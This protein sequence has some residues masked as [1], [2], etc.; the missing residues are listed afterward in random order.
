MRAARGAA[1]LA[2][3]VATGLVLSACTPAEPEESS[4]V[5]RIATVDNG[6]MKRMQELADEFNASNRPMEIVFET[7]REGELRQQVTTDINTGGGR[8]D[9]VTLGT[10]E[11]PIWAERG[12]L[13]P[14]DAMPAAYQ[15][16]DIL[17]TIRES[18]SY[19]GSLYA[20]PFYGESSFT[21][22]R[23]D[24]FEEAGIEMPEEP[25]WDFIVDAATRLNDP[26][27]GVN[28]ACLRGA[29]G[30]GENMALLTSMANSYGGRWFDDN[31][32]PQLETQPWVDALT[33][34]TELGANADP[35][36]STMG[37]NANLD[38]FREGKCAIWIDATAAGSF[39]VDPEGSEVADSVGFAKAPGTGLEKNSNWLWAW[40]LAVTKSAKNKDVATEFVT[41]ATS[42][43]YTELVAEEYGWGNVPP[44]ARLS[45]Y[46]NEDYLKAAPYADLA[47]AAIQNSDPADPTV[48]PV[49]YTGVQYVSVPEFQGIGTAVGNRVAL[50]L[51]GQLSVAQALEDSQWVTTEVS[52]R[53]RLIEEAN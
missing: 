6:D 49:P 38:L 42:K 20:L 26:E 39:I 50:A 46:E 24:L 40:S 52:D 5:L 34:Y 25:D 37:Y 7:M 30:W 9:I 29:P 36:S 19:D 18:L 43:E 15:V 21:M 53:I 2:V 44:G 14:M 35:E 10:Y 45:L 3:A 51:Q 33:T 31:W 13:E 41:W 28:G 32:V 11:A 47:L 4:N 1:A 48:E 23:T 16:D 17:P 12:W 8:F 22:Y 27:G